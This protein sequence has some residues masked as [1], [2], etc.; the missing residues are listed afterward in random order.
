MDRNQAILGFQIRN[1]KASIDNK[2]IRTVVTRNNKACV[3]RKTLEVEA[4]R[5]VSRQNISQ[6]VSHEIGES[7]VGP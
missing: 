6:N 5:Y 3:R 4:T 2:A 7:V 1:I